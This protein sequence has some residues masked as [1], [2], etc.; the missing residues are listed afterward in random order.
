[1]PQ[2]YYRPP[3]YI[4]LERLLALE[5]PQLWQ[6]RSFLCFELRLTELFSGIGFTMTSEGT[7]GLR[8]YPGVDEK[9]TSLARYRL[10]DLERR[11]SSNWNQI[12]FILFVDNLSQVFYE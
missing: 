5:N 9:V 10:I 3:D 7:R 6:V 1:M 4:N 11:P 2:K 12:C 8:E